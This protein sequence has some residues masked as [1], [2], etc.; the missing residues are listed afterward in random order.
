M[1]LRLFL[2]LFRKEVVERFRGM[3]VALCVQFLLYGGLGVAFIWFY[4]KFSA[5]Y[6]GI[7]GDAA[8]RFFEL[9]SL[10]LAVLLALTTVGAAVSIVR[11][12]RLA[13]DMRLFAALPV[14]PRI[15]LAA[16]L[17]DIVLWQLLLAAAAV[18][19]FAF[20]PNGAEIPWYF[21]VLVILS[22]PALSLALGVILAFP[23][24][25][26]VRFL[27]GKFLFSFLMGTALFGALLYLYSFALGGVKE[28]LLGGD[29]KYFFGEKVL[30]G[31]GLAARYSY[32]SSM[33]AQLL[34][35]GR[36]G[37]YAPLTAGIV[38]IAPFV[39]FFL[40]KNFLK[41][42]LAQ[43]PAGRSPRLTART[44]RKPKFFALLTKEFVQIFR[45]PAYAFSYFSVAVVMPLMIYFCMSVGDSLLEQLLGVSCSFELSVFLTLL[46][47][48]LTN[49]FC[50][51]NVSRE[52]RMFS[53]LKALPVSAGQVFSAKI[54]LSMLTVSLSLF[55]SSVAQWAANFLTFPAALA[56]FAIGLVFS[57]AQVC[58]ATRY[59][60]THPRFSAE[61]DG[62]VGEGDGVSLLWLALSLLLGGGLL[63]GKL[64]ATLR[65]GSFPALY[66]VLFA[67]G[68]SLLA[69]VFSVFRLFFGLQKRYE[70]FS[71]G[72]V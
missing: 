55:A 57:F 64:F 39:C 22:L 69:A 17:A 3:G 41:D 47:S 35:G 20:V 23:V 63:V 5:V 70:R 46:Y 51:T 30:R 72:T 68:V 31:I 26:L 4:M 7:G 45:T 42:A 9:L 37:L 18:S 53:V 1:K 43:K 61:T 38:L 19:V 48:A 56:V 33:L 40:S 50:T 25:A 54:F 28:L 24:H 29:L 65:F 11:S 10:S 60:F 6:L 2:V 66:T 21:F 13:E 14:S 62:E 49:V 58:F 15:L 67:G 52:G 12:V 36:A 34:I 16:K 32:P 71:G 27:R 59:D 8:A 44:T